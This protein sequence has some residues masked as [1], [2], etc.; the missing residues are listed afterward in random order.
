MH[1]ALSARGV[2]VDGTIVPLGDLDDDGG[3]DDTDDSE[4][5]AEVLH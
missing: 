1:N 5:D 4:T 2:T 3:D